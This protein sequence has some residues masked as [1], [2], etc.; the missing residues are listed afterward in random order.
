MIR[1]GMVLVLLGLM[2]TLVLGALF[3]LAG[4]G[5]VVVVQV[6]RWL[7]LEPAST[8]WLADGLDAAGAIARWL[9]AIVWALGVAMLVAVGR[10]LARV[11]PPAPDRARGAPGSGAPGVTIDGAARRVDGRGRPGRPADRN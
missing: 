9:F 2:W 10:L 4:A 11:R 3:L 7:D 8:Q 5:S 6:T 1:P